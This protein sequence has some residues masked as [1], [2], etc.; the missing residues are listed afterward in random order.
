M[1]I[2]DRVGHLLD[3]VKAI[4]IDDLERVVQYAHE[5]DIQSVN[6]PPQR[7]PITRQALRMFWMFRRNIDAVDIRVEVDE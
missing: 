4:D 3:S 7:F 6:A 1:P 5:C 2:V